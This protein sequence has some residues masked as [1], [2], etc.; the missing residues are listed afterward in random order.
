MFIAQTLYST[1][2]CCLSVIPLDSPILEYAEE[3]ADKRFELTCEDCKH[4]VDRDSNNRKQLSSLV[5]AIVSTW[6]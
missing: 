5:E 6:R 2:K 3:V 1:G 4:S